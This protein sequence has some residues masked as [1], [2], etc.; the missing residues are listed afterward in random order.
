VSPP[1]RN[2]QERAEGCARVMWSEDRASQSLGLGMV[3]IAPGEAVLSMTVRADMTNG[4]GTCH[5]GLIFALAD[6]AF[7][8]ACNSYDERAVAHHCDITFVRPGRLG[9]RL[10]A[11]AI[12]RSRSGRSGIY[13]VTVRD[14]LGEVVAEFRGHSRTIGGSLTGAEARQK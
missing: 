14:D 8:F 12:E 4:H 2:A 7:A 6:S 1:E 3:R 11:E 9:Q 5:G 13:D 10:T